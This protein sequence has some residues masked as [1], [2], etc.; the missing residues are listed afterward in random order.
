VTAAAPV[1]VLTAVTGAAWE[2]DLV[3]ELDGGGHG[4]TVVRRC[5]DVPEVL[6]AAASGLGRVVLLAADLRSLDRDAVA[7]LAAVDVAVVGLTDPGDTVAEERL[8]RL[9][10]VRVLAVDAGAAAVARAAL[11]ADRDRG[12]A[13]DPASPP[14]PPR[15][16]GRGRTV[17]V[18]GPT[19]APGR[20]TVAVGVADDCA[21]LGVPTLLVDA[22]VYGGVLA[23]VLGLLDDSAGLAAAC[24]AAGAGRL[25]EAALA[26]LAWQLRPALRVLTGIVRAD[27]WPELGPA[28]LT[29]VLEVARH[30]AALT[31]VD[32]GFSLEQDE[33][34]SYDTAAPRRNGATLAVLAAA[35]TVLC[36]GTADPVGLQRLIRALAEL[37]ATAPDVRPL[38]VVNRV[39]PGVIDGDPRQELAVALRTWAGIT[40]LTFLPWAPDALDAAGLSGRTVAEVAPASPLRLALAELAR[41]L[42]GVPPTRSRRGPLGVRRRRTLV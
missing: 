12:E 21:R 14:R 32:C 15:L 8:H 37:H 6:A 10:V 40:D 31:I 36:V 23:Q 20:T 38:V 29:E 4:L 22:D 30:L 24:R 33:E 2:S 13:A 11:H 7:R 26:E 35:D 19:G 18:W 34:L 17:A 42:S 3:A 5:V 39:R 41:R 9:G 16:P 1:P 28:A 25:D 27:R